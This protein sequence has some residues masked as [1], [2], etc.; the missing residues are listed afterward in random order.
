MNYQLSP[1]EIT[2]IG[3]AQK[4]DSGM[5]IS[6]SSIISRDPNPIK[7]RFADWQKLVKYESGGKSNH[8]VWEGKL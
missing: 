6:T 4:A 5:Q 1:D 3:D 2:R 7:R 8:A